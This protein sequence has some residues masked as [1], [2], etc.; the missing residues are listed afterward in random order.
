M[1][2]LPRLLHHIVGSRHRRNPLDS[3]RRVNTRL[4]LHVAQCQDKRL[5]RQDHIRLRVLPDLRDPQDPR[6]LTDRLRDLLALV[7]APMLIRPLSGHQGR[8]RIT[9]DLLQSCGPVRM[10]PLEP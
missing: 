1:L 2:V 5:L 4:H 3:L 6:T 7:A 8:V 9:V 10:V